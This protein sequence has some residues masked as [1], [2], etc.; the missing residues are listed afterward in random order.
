MGEEKELKQILTNP[1]SN[2][3][4]LEEAI[5][6]L[7]DLHSDEA[8]EVMAEVEKDPL[9]PQWLRGMARGYLAKERK[10]S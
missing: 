10:N 1:F 6:D 7:A 5:S 9:R 8:M 3:R 4:E 2:Y